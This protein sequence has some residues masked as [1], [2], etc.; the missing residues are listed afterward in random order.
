MNLLSSKSVSRHIFSVLV[1]MLS[2]MF[3]AACSSADDKGKML[4]AQLKAELPPG[5][6]LTQTLS[7]LKSRNVTF[8]QKTIR[9]CDALVKQARVQ[10][11][12]TTKGGP[13]IF[14]KAQIDRSWYG[15]HTDLILQLVFNTDEVLMDGNYE[16]LDNSF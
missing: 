6:S 13:C 14:G 5:V 3:I 9:E 16:I 4:M 11:Q 1:V 12:L 10:T 15:A 7:I 2:A 8:S